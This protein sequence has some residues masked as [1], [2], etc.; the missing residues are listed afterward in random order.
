LTSRRLCSQYV[1]IARRRIPEATVDYA[2]WLARELEGRSG[3]VHLSP[4]TSLFVAMALSG[5]AE[6]LDQSDAGRL[7]FIVT[8]TDGA[9]SEVI[10]AA[11]NLSVAAAAFTAATIA[12]P[13]VDLIL[14]HGTRVVSERIIAKAD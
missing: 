9:H 10:A 3:V 11:E 2:R 4:E 6:K 14:R 7:P 13:R 8:A 1:L 12:R 5:Y